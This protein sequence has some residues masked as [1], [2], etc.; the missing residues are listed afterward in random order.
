MMNHNLDIIPKATLTLLE[1]KS[2]LKK[3][4]VG[5]TA[6]EIQRIMISSQETMDILA[7]LQAKFKVFIQASEDFPSF[8]IQSK[9]LKDPHLLYQC[10]SLT[11]MIVSSLKSHL[12]E[13]NYLRREVKTLID[14]LGL[15]HKELQFS[16]ENKE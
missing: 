13:I 3:K 14:W 6:K 10:T 9:K 4:G 8:F 7:L 11:K 15:L 2:T 1:F 5:L 16:Q 12:D